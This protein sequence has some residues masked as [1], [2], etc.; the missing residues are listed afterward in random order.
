MTL[1]LRFIGFTIILSALTACNDPGYPEHLRVEKI[2]TDNLQAIL[3][4]PKSAD[5]DSRPLTTSIVLGGSEGG[6]GGASQTAATLAEHGIAALAVGYFGIEGIPTK[7]KQVPIEYVDAAI[8]YIDSSPRLTRNHCQQVAVVGSSRGAELA[9]LLGTYNQDYAP[10]IAISPSSHVWG[11]IGEPNTAAWTYQ[12]EPLNFVPR[13]S[14]PDYSAETFWG[15]DY[16]LSDINNADAKLA[17]IDASQIKGQVLLF[18]GADDQLWPSTFMAQNL[19]ESISRHGAAARVELQVYADAGHVITPGLKSDLTQVQTQTGQNIMLGGSESANSAAQKDVLTRILAAIKSP[20]CYDSRAKFNEQKLDKLSEFLATTNTSS[21]VLMRG[22]EVVF[23]FGNIYEK[24]T[25][26]SIRKPMLNA[27]YGLYVDRGIIDLDMTLEELGVDDITPLT[28]LEKA[29]TIRQILKARSGIYLP[30]AATNEAMISMLPERGS[31]APGEKY[32]YNNWDFNVAGSIF[33]KLTGERIYEVFHRE[34]ATPLGMK[35]FNG[36]YTTIDENT[37]ISELNVDGF[38]QPELNKSKHPAY[39]FRMSAYDMALFGQL[40]EN[41]GVWNGQNILSREW[42]EAS[43]TSYSL[44]NRYMD[45]GYGML[46]NVINPNDKRPNK[47]FYH[48]GVGIHM[49]GVYPSDDLVLVHRVQTEQDYNFDK[50]DLYK[51]IGL[52]FSALED[53]PE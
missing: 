21:L 42:V 29:A 27:L 45:F 52:T 9:L 22:G 38:Y 28:E 15:R 10:I 49:L 5:T 7:L 2:D 11:A 8:N 20:T 36:E 26:H 14:Q 39:H 47:S 23:Q 41:F 25:I 19:A 32:V 13:H 35:Q 44:T 24:H 18:A 34:I 40:Y 43:T 46:W 3:F 53:Y 30:A 1:L 16:F 12:G 31:F 33:E 6:F 48:T 4:T 17:K 51:I 50:Q 37:S